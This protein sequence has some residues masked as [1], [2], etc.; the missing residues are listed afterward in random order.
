MDLKRWDVT[1]TQIE[2]KMNKKNIEKCGIFFN[3]RDIL[4]AQKI[5]RREVC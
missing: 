2:I 5:K 1:S 3:E 4:N